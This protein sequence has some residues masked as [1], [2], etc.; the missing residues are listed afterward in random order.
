M[1]ERRFILLLLAGFCWD[2]AAKPVPVH[3]GP[4][5]GILTEYPHAQ[6]RMGQD[7]SLLA[8]QS[9][10]HPHAQKAVTAESVIVAPPHHPSDVSLFK[11]GA[12]AGLHSTTSSSPSPELFAG[13]DGFVELMISHPD[14]EPP[15]EPD[16]RCFTDSWPQVAADL[17]RTDPE[18]CS[19]ITRRPHWAYV[20]CRAGPGAAGLPDLFAALC[21]ASGGEIT[22]VV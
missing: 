10:L 15:V 19:L 12:E 8:S 17:W 21:H 16:W 13:W 22:R 3:S 7:S 6:G 4:G 2:S 1:L 5:T 20:E 14:A 18:S 11:F 9:Q